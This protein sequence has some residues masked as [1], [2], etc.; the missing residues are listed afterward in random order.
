MDRLAAG[1]GVLDARIVFHVVGSKKI[2]PAIIAA[3]DRSIR[4]ERAERATGDA[5]TAA[6]A[7]CTAALGGDVDHRRRT[8][9][10]LGRQCA[11]EQFHALDRACIQALAEAA[12]GFGNDHAIDAVLQVGVIAAHMQA[13]VRILHHAGRL[14][15]HLVHRRGRAERQLA[16]RLL[17]DHVLA[18]AGFR[19]QRIA[20]LI[21][22]GRY[23]NRAQLLH[24]GRRP[25]ATA[26]VHRL[27]FSRC[28]RGCGGVHFR[29]RLGGVDGGRT[30]RYGQAEGNHG[31]LHR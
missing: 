27:A 25:V 31:R 1:S 10:V 12:D 15:Q 24:L 7:K 11:V 4:I 21:Q 17:I 14:Q 8:Q 28:C 6:V 13:A 5:H 22:R 9:P 29:G 2:A 20:R 23:R 26:P 19:R 18:A 30:Q 3:P 16:D